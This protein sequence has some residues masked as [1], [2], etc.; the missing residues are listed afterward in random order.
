[1]LYLLQIVLQCAAILAGGAAAAQS[2]HKQ[3]EKI[4]DAVREEYNRRSQD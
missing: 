3:D 4:K 2:R 1:M